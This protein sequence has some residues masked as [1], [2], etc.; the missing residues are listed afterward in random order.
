MIR[1]SPSLS[2]IKFC[3]NLTR[4]HIDHSAKS[5]AISNFR[6]KYSLCK[7]IIT[8]YF[9]L[10]FDL[11]SKL[12]INKS[13]QFRYSGVFVCAPNSLYQTVRITFYLLLFHGQRLCNSIR[14]ETDTPNTAEFYQLRTQL[15]GKFSETLKI[16][17]HFVLC[18]FT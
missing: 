6:V 16:N 14:K 9:S 17:K 7:F 18:C 2:S 4:I 1:K 5:F 12:H 10:C 8:V 13:N 11:C 15:Y 3:S